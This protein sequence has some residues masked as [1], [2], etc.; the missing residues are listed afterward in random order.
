[1]IKR[2]TKLMTICEKFTTPISTDKEGKLKGGFCGISNDSSQ[3]MLRDNVKCS[4]S[5]CKHIS[6]YN[7]T[8]CRNLECGNGECKNVGCVNDL[9]CYT[10]TTG[11]PTTK[12]NSNTSLWLETSLL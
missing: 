8:N 10:I 6:C 12:E 1:M 3:S 7:G 2:K 11:E 5:S 4:N 9:Q